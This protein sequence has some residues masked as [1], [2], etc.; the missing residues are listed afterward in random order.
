MRTLFKWDVVLLLAAVAALVMSPIVA[1]QNQPPAP[2]PQRGH[3]AGKLILGGDVASFDNPA[4]LPTHCVLTNRFKRGQRMGFRMRAIDGG[5]GEIENTAVLT[6]HVTHAGKTVDVPM[7][8][9]G[10]A[11]YPKEEYS[12]A[13]DDMWTGVW[14]VPADAPVGVVSYTITATDRFG[15]TAT[16]TPFPNV[17]SQ[18]AVVE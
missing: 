7:R 2:M 12:R 9:R 18:L 16:F 1:G 6:A 8:W 13:P 11:P 4:G 10:N 14:T 17:V 5:T 15:R 3:P